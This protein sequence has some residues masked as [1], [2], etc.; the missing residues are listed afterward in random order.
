MSSKLKTAVVVNDSNVVDGNTADAAI[1]NVPY[2]NTEDELRAGRMAV[3]D[4]DTHLKNLE[5]AI[6][7][8][9]GQ[10]A[11]TKQNVGSNEEIQLNLDAN[12]V[13]NGHV[14]MANGVGGWSWAA[15]GGGGA[16]PVDVT[17]VAG[18]ALAL[19]D[20]VYLDETSST[21]FKVD[22]DA[23]PVKCGRFRGIVN[24]GAISSAASGSIRMIGEVAGFSSLTP[25][26][27]V[28][29]STTAGGIT[30]TKPTPTL[31][32]S[33]IGIAEIGVAVSATNILVYPSRGIPVQYMLRASLA[34]NATLT[35]QHHSDAMG[36]SRRPYAY[37]GSSE[38]GILLTTYSSSNQDANKNL[39]NRTIATY[40]VDQC[41]GGTPIGNMT[42][43]GGLA[44]A[45]DNNAGVGA[46]RTAVSGQI[47]YDF[48]VGITKSIRRYTV[49]EI[50]TQPETSAPSAWTLEYSS[51]NSNWTIADT[52]AGQTGWTNGQVRTFDVSVAAAARYWRLNVTN[53]NGAA[54]LFIGEIEMMEVA[55]YTNGPQQLEQSFQIAAASVSSIRLWLRK[56]GSP[57]GNLTAKIWTDSGGNPNAVVTNGTSDTVVASTLSSSYGFIEF[58]FATPASLSASTTY[59]VTL[60]TTDSYS[61]FDYVQWGVDGSAPAY[62]SGEFKSFNGTSHSAESADGVFEVYG[63]GTTFNELAVIG[64]WSGGTRDIAVRYDDGSGADSSVKTTCKNVTGVT[65]D[66]TL[67]VE[68]R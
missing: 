56:V 63:I 64:R 66:V 10:F 15:P 65:Q 17:G 11:I 31:G 9:A 4:T 46:G 40:T 5:D 8:V 20:Y 12:G 2:A 57:A 39:K 14:P 44:A 49:T 58:I 38:A 50:S 54:S 35:I 1:W 32:G 59:W 55:T 13:T 26:L 47:G 18:E 43:A 36:H 62:A 67:V 45:F 34:N 48:G 53:N 6:K 16:A 19:R 68:I 51:D 28:Y 25:G 42:S 21:W 22:T 7:G 61:E 3:S 60:E 41:T 33:Q 52:R 29:A 27:P 23:T 30:Q 37:T 24:V